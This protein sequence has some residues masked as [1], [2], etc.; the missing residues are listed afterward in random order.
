[1]TPDE[2]A[3]LDRLRKI[4]AAWPEAVTAINA[5]MNQLREALGQPPREQE[6]R[7]ERE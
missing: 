3:E 4:E 6:Q 1:M 5:H 7:G 2:H